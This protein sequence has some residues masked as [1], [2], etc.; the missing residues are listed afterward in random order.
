MESIMTCIVV[1]LAVVAYE[2]KR[3]QSVFLASEASF[4]SSCVRLRVVAKVSPSC[5]I[6]SRDSRSEVSVTIL[7]LGRS[8]W[9]RLQSAHVKTTGQRRRQTGKVGTDAAGYAGSWATFYSPS[10]ALGYTT[11]SGACKAENNDP[12]EC[13]SKRPLKGVL[14]CVGRDR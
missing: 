1:S 4:G 8:G 2:M 12:V 14:R 13:D 7:V 10:G 11:S 5:R 6:G 9:L 3:M